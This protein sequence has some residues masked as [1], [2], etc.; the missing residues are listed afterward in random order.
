MEESQ[1]EFIPSLSTPL[2]L[3]IL[4]NYRTSWTPTHRQL[5]QP[6]PGLH[7]EM[8]KSINLLQT[9]PIISWLQL[10]DDFELICPKNP[11]KVPLNSLKDK[12]EHSPALYYIHQSQD[13]AH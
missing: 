7:E 2:S 1:P 6:N 9:Y 10:P 3:L 8:R 12:E 4:L 11:P 13:F 5:D